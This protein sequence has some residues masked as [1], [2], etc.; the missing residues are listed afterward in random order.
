M[1]NYR[2]Y[3]AQLSVAEGYLHLK[4]Y[5]KM[6]DTLEAIT[7]TFYE[8]NMLDAKF[9]YLKGRLFEENHNLEMAKH[10][11]WTAF[12][13]ECKDVK[14]C[15]TIAEALQRVLVTTNECRSIYCMYVGKENHQH[16]LQPV[17]DKR[18]VVVDDTIVCNKEDL[19]KNDFVDLYVCQYN[20]EEVF[21]SLSFVKRLM[22]DK[23][24][25]MSDFYAYE[26]N[27]PYIFISYS[28]KDEQ[29]VLRIIEALQT[30]GYR[31]WFDRGIEVGTEWPQN[32]AE[33]IVNS[34]CVISFMSENA[35]SSQNCRNEINFAMN[36]SKNFITVYLHA[37]EM[38][39]GLQLQLGS[40]QAIYKNRSASF[41]QF[42]DELDRVK[43]MQE[44]K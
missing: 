34:A 40:K 3:E 9:Y 29:E 25:N 16:I 24:Y 22:D 26:G 17:T 11:Y 27:Q 44:C 28:H 7:E 32:I 2:D 38:E 33:H 35:A 41:E 36:Y 19:Q 6:I 10:D 21:T 15:Y 42:M 12:S 14:L 1:H 37:F 43:F 23:T 5:E 4:D 8:D 18:R 13:C 39:L 31:V 30:R 20:G